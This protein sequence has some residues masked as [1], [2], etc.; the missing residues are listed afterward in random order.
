MNL[1]PQQDA[2]NELQLNVPIPPPTKESRDLA[3][4]AATKAGKGAH[5]GIKNA[6]AAVQKRLRNM[7]LKKTARPD[8]LKKASK[9]MET[10]VK[11][12]VEDADKT[13]ETARKS[14]EQA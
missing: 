14:M 7:E 3:L 5:D 12:A 13:V 10:I 1:Q 9:H 4:A 6:R 8:D 11:K 2:H